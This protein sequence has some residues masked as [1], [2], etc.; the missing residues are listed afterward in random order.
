MNPGT[1]CVTGRHRQSER[2]SSRFAAISVSLP[3]IV[4]GIITILGWL[5]FVFCF[6]E[7]DKHVF[8]EV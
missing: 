5:L 7:K 1:R 6:R 3:I 2:C 4:S 8:H